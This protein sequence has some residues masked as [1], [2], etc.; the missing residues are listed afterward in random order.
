MHTLDA[1]LRMSG[2]AF[3]ASLPGSPLV[4]E[5][6]GLPNPCAAG[7]VQAQTLTHFAGV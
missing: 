1:L 4:L 6:H 3:R 5:A 2:P 7:M